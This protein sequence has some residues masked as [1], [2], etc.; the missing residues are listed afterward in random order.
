MTTASQ[1]TPPQLRSREEI[2]AM[3]ELLATYYPP[4]DDYLTGVMTTLRWALGA[5][6]TA[7]VSR[8]VLGRPVTARDASRE[9]TAAYQ[10]MG[11][12]G[13]ALQCELGRRYLTGAEHATAWLTG[14]PSFAVPDGWPWPNN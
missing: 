11:L 7:P 14:S 9:H 2:A 4:G 8:T 10:G 5:L 13:R 6:D 12:Q 3:I 1:Y